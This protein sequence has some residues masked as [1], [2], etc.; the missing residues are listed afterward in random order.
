[1]S[2]DLT[3]INQTEIPVTS[4]PILPL[5]QAIS[6]LAPNCNWQLEGFYYEGLV[7]LD[8]ISKK[9]SKEAVEARA[10]EI[11]AQV[12]WRRLRKERDQR[13]KEVDWVTLRSVRSGEPI[14]QE[15]R[16]YMQV[17]ADITE[18]ADPMIV[19]G[20]LVNITWPERPDGEPAGPYRG[21]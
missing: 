2:E 6:E 17:L 13:M 21:R 8:D 15:W 7:W 16:D 18:N 5:P 14:P 4:G 19:E 11:M 3:Q 12:P 20:E 9:P 1:M 10:R